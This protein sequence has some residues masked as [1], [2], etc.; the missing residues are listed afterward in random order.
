[1]LSSDVPVLANFASHCALLAVGLRHTFGVGT[2]QAGVPIT[3][4]QRWLGHS[5]LTTTAIY[6]AAV[7]PEEL[8]FASRFWSW[9]S[10]VNAPVQMLGRKQAHKL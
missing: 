6:A 3:L 2:V 9:C 4:V 5:R 1:L 10:V 8:E 7:G